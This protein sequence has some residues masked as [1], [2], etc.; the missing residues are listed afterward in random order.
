MKMLT[1]ADGARGEGVGT[2]V[3]RYYRGVNDR[4]FC[5]QYATYTWRHRRERIGE[6]GCNKKKIKRKK[7]ESTESI[8]AGGGYDMSL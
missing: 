5:L 6:L 3:V 4:C 8:D 7:K 2:D 1:V